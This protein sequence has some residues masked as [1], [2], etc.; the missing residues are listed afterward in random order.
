M[1][2][3]PRGDTSSSPGPANAL[4]SPRPMRSGGLVAGRGATGPTDPRR[5]GDVA[6]GVGRV[7]SRLRGSDLVD[8]VLPRECGGCLRPGADWCVRCQRSLLGLAF[9][10]PAGGPPRLGA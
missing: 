10:A 3:S 5:R 8:L 4:T 9:E 6:S 2:T 1:S 7:L